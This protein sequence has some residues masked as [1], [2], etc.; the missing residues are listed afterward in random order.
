MAS[1]AGSTLAHRSVASIRGGPPQG[2]SPT[3]PHTPNRSSVISSYGSP[4]TIRA[5][6]EFIVVELGSRHIRVG[7]AGDTSPR[8]VLQCSPEDQRRAGDFRGWQQ[9]KRSPGLQWSKEYEFWRYDLR[10]I[11]LGL[12]QDKLERVLHDAFSKF[13]YLKYHKGQLLTCIQILAHRFQTTKTWAGLRL[14]STSTTADSH[15]GYTVQQI[16]VA[17][18]LSHV[19]TIYVGHLR[20]TIEPLIP[21]E[22]DVAKQRALGFEECEDIMCRLMWCKPSEFRSSQRQSTQLETVDEQEEIEA[23]SAQ[24]GVPT[25]VAQIPI[26][27]SRRPVTVELPFEKLAEVC[28]DTFFDPSA[29]RATFDD[30][31]LPLHLL[32]YRHL[33][34][35]PLDVRAVCM[36]RIMF[37]GGCS[38]ILGIKQ[39]IIDDLTAIV[40]KRGWEPVFGKVVDK[41]RNSARIHQ[42]SST[43]S[44]T[45]GSPSSSPGEAE[46]RK[47]PK[48]AADSKPEHDPIE[49][50]VVRQRAT[51]PQFKGQIRVIHTLGPWVGGSLLCQLKIPAM[52]IID[53]ESWLLQGVNGASRPSEVDFKAQHRQSVQAG[54]YARGGG[55]HHGNWTLGV[56]G[57]LFADAKR[58]PSAPKPI[59]DI[60]HIRQHAELYQQTCVERNYRNQAQNPAKILEL[61]A[62]WQDLQRQGRA[63]RERSNLLRRQLANPATSSDDEDLKEVRQLTREQIQEEARQLKQDLSAIEKGES[64][65][66]TQ[67]EELALE[68]PNLTHPDTPKGSD[69]EVMSYINDPP[70]FT[71]SPE[72][73]IWRSHV[74][75]GSELGI[76]DFAGAATASGWGWYY[77]LGEAAQ[78]EQALV[79]YALAVATRHGW[80]QVSPPSMVYSHIGA[81]CGFQPRDLNGEQQVYT[82]AQSAEDAER[83]VP[84]MCLTGTSEIALAGMKAN[85]T[86]DSED[87]PLKRVAVSRCYRAEA[88]ARGADTKGLYRVHE[89]TKV[90]MFAWTA[91]DEDIAQELFDE[92]LDLQTEILSSLGLYCRILSM[93][94]HDLG[95]SATRKIDMEAFFPSR[96]DN[97]GEVT[98]ASMCT[99]YQTRRLGTRTRID[100]KLA[101]PWTSNGTALA[102]PRVIAAILENGWDEEAKTVTIPECLRPWMDGKEKIGLGGRRSSVDRV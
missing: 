33:L 77:L 63:L 86:L 17:N 10:D 51:V 92:M 84:E 73:K 29:D 19:N 71:E 21:G 81:A 83:G 54:G 27:T 6:D 72:D 49:A 57:Y 25:G 37:T 7:F 91:P 88:G 16:S 98:S 85:T 20:R 9:P 64:Q 56:W 52:A 14:W 102:V 38:S 93:P 75:I 44:P 78:L 62:R 48:N 45:E 74:H 61:H 40:N 8:V 32:L 46:Q 55:G 23:E 69:F 28:D 101:F 60:K 90:E 70:T 50:K 13:V 47:S 36:S 58:P 43:T 59:V 22:H 3:T 34:Q 95:A 12:Y 11:Q 65:A 5:D 97:W 15:F 39:R 41:H 53:R 99:D 24:A 80:T 87:L 35:L 2:P 26:N 42:Q 1:G 94:S 89:F 100:G 96:R 31:E 4:S 79:Q 67:M 66:V 82:I 76:F 30:D 68:L 18:Y